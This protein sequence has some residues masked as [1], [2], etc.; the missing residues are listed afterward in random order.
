LSSFHQQKL[1]KAK[2]I[3]DAMQSTQNNLTRVQQE[4]NI[5]AAQIQILETRKGQMTREL[6]DQKQKIQRAQV[7]V[8]K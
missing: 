8:Q 6:I 1:D 7:S 4:F 3:E 5:F 2:V